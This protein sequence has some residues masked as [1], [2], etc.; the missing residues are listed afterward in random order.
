MYKVKMKLDEAE[1]RRLMAV[2][3]VD[4]MLAPVN[5]DAGLSAVILKKIKVKKVEEVKHDDTQDD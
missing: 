3:H 4:A 1:Y 5:P 2:L